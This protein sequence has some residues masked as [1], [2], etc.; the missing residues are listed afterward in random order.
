M[1]ASRIFLYFCLS[2]IGGIFLNSII[3][4]PQLLTLGI[5]ISGILLISVLWKY[6]K[7]VVIGF[8]LIFLVTGIWRHQAAELKI[9]NNELRSYNDLEKNITLKGQVIGEPDIRANNIKLTI[10][11]EDI[12]GKI[13]VTTNRY[14]EY[15][16]G[17][18]LKIT[19]K[20][21]TPQELEDFNYRDY[22]AK[23]GIYSVMSWPEI[24]VIEQGFGNPIKSSL[25]S[26][27]KKFQE[28]TEKFI[29]PP[30]IG[31]LEALFSG[32][33]S[34]ISKEWKEKL[35]ITGT[36]HITAV[37]GMNITII[38]VLIMSFL[39]NLGFWRQQALCLSI[40]L[41]LLYILMIGFPASAVRAGIMA[42]L[43]MLAQYFGRLSLAQR[44]VVFAGTAMLVLNPLLLKLD[45]G[46]QLS[47]LAIL[48]LIY[49]QP[50]FFEKLKKI[51][52]L[53]IFP[54]R[55]TLSATLAAQIFT[56]PILVYNFGYIS[57]IS[58]ITNILI[59][60]FLAPITILIFIFGLS[61]MI[62]QPLGWVLSW[63]SWL[64]LTYLVKVID[65]FSQVPKASFAI[66]WIWLM[67]FYLILGLI[68]W[69]LNQKQ[70]L[71]FLNY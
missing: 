9:T 31:I 66:S 20:L 47:F 42:G 7:F 70:K 65:F 17:D 10:K 52:N 34:N 27:K 18:K 55:V 25:F 64:L 43:L 1:T 41:I 61:G 58:P 15:Q 56:L 63:P 36:R 4:I 50:T 5:L 46:F 16:Y 24:E 68:T 23:D 44:A 67:V 13:L 37:S 35:N 14:P 51:P 32:D 29:S 3:K 21:E 2:F 26:F 11:P 30:Q 57:L 40:F 49:F 33:E 69:R 22:L 53:K 39:L 12:D 71:K 38:A 60:P 48:G 6:K 45:I 54:A 59:V 19:G 62:L 8:C 28:T